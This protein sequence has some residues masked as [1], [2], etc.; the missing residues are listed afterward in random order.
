MYVDGS[1]RLDTA[2]H[3]RW[4]RV[5]DVLAYLHQ[6]RAYLLHSDMFQLPS[7]RPAAPPVSNSAK[8]FP[9]N[10]VYICEGIGEW[11]S[12]LQKMQHLTSVLVHPHRLS[13]GYHQS[14]S[15]GNAELLLLRLINASLLAYEAADSFVD[16]ALFEN[17]Y[18]MVWVD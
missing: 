8:R 14:R 13:K 17:R 9:S 3:L 7:L 4:Y 15:L 10:T 12:R 18:S 16:R 5:K 11:N 1:L 6:V 2:K